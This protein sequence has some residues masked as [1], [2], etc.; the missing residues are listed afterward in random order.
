[1]LAQ[2]ML[3]KTFARLHTK[4]AADQEEFLDETVRPLSPRWIRRTRW[5]RNSPCERAGARAACIRPGDAALG[6][7]LHPDLRPHAWYACGP[8]VPTHRSTEELT[9]LG[10]LSCSPVWQR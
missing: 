9:T 5:R 7:R 2:K 8:S 6:A 3:A 1:M 4:V 10:A